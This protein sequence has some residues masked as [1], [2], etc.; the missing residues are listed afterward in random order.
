[1]SVR[2]TAP[3][4]QVELC[5]KRLW[6]EF[7]ILS[8]FQTTDWL[9]SWILCKWISQAFFFYFILI[10][11]RDLQGI[12]T[13]LLREKVFRLTVQDC[14]G[15]LFHIYLFFLNAFNLSHPAEA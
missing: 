8:A 14:T 3:F 12:Q 11:Q 1:M 15:T 10:R 5:T 13:L 7:D 9:I 4:A 2:K 6:V